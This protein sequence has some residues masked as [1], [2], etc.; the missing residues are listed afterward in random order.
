[1][2]KLLDF[3]REVRDEIYYFTLQQPLRY[4]STV[5]DAHTLWDSVPGASTLS[6]QDEVARWQPKNPNPKF[7]TPT[8]LPLLVVNHQIH[9]EVISTIDRIRREGNL[10]FTLSLYWPLFADGRRKPLLGWT[11]VPAFSR[12]VNMLKLEIWLPAFRKDADSERQIYDMAFANFEQ[13][14]LLRAGLQCPQHGFLTSLFN[15]LM[16]WGWRAECSRQPPCNPKFLVDSYSFHVFTVIDDSIELE[17]VP[18]WEQQQSPFDNMLSIEK[19]TR[20]SS[21][22]YHHVAE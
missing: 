21:W 18:I 8:S 4:P 14:V 9:D 2:V 10:S 3:P 1:M 5:Q 22:A 13:L 15:K 12:H 20:D 19:E 17:P 6:F 7:P 11:H 16:G